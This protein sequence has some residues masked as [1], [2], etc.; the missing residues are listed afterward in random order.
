M[1]IHIIIIIIIIIVS[2]II[3][4]MIIHIIIII[5][6][7][8]IIVILLWLFTLLSLLSSLVSSLLFHSTLFVGRNALG[9]VLSASR[10]SRAVGVPT[11]NFLG[12]ACVKLYM[13]CTYIIL[14]S[15][16]SSARRVWSYIHYI[17][18]AW[19]HKLCMLV[20]ANGDTDDDNDNVIS[21]LIIRIIRIIMIIITTIIRIDVRPHQATCF[22]HCRPAP[23]TNITG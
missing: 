2:I 21:I 11:K 4:V 14:I 9:L 15:K 22:S 10:K 13:L 7:I 19:H 8:I 12:S 1:I 17:S 5:I 18:S 23:Q 3:I 20:C 6:I 16:I